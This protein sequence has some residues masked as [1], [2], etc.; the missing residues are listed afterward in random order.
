M[1]VIAAGCVVGL[2]V[3]AIL[4]GVGFATTA[5]RAKTHVHAW[6][7]FAVASGVFLCL[8]IVGVYVFPYETVKPSSDYDILA[9][10]LFLQGLGYCAAPGVAGL[11]A[12][13]AARLSSP[14]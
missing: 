10:N 4:G 11:L 3:T 2:I 8:L 13:I 1:F 6:R 7:Y 12:A 14:K 9:R 5:K